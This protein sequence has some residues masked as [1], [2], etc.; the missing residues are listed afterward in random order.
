MLVAAEEYIVSTHLWAFALGI[1]AHWAPILTGGVFSV[2]MLIWNQ[3]LERKY[4]LWVMAGA[5]LVSS[6]LAWRDQFASAEWRGAEIGRMSAV[7]DSQEKQ[8]KSAGGQNETLQADLANKDRPINVIVPTNSDI[9]EILHRQDR[10]LAEMKSQMPT[11]KK[12]ALQLSNDLLRFLN[13]RE[14]TRPPYPDTNNNSSWDKWSSLAGQWVYETSSQERIRFAVTIAEVI[15]D[16]EDKNTGVP[17]ALRDYCLQFDG[18]PF[19]IQ[20]CATDIGLFAQKL[21]D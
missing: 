21:P 9:K 7:I 8:L 11:A 12:K 15:Q 14:K 13:E 3:P 17:Q 16:M 2:I 19:H 5:I 18:I 6:F 10:E 1:W 20:R 4:I